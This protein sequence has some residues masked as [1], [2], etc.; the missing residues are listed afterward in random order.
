VSL[1]VYKGQ[2]ARVKTT[3]LWVLLSRLV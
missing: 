3:Q 1:N 2:A